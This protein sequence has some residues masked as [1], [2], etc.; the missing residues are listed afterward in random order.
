M[1]SRM[2]DGMAP[3]TLFSTHSHTYKSW[4][5]SAHRSGMEPVHSLRVKSDLRY[6]CTQQGPT[7]FSFNWFTLLH[8]MTSRALSHHRPSR[9][10]RRQPRMRKLFRAVSNASIENYF[11]II[12]VLCKLSCYSPTYALPHLFPKICTNIQ[13][14][15]SWKVRYDPVQRVPYM[16]Q[17][18]K[19]IGYEDNDSIRE[20]VSGD[21]FYI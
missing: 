16:V 10:L 9:F 8:Y 3:L 11:E 5:L 1:H 20:K 15:S 18:E 19:W 4:S 21:R 12:S 2:A 14:P 7:A 6:P 13:Q 17:G